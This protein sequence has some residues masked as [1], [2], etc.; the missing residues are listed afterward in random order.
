MHVCTQRWVDEGGAA[1]LAWE[2]ALK[3]AAGARSIVRGW[4]FKV[5]LVLHPQSYGVWH[6]LR[7]AMF[8]PF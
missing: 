4:R 7:A 3:L 2:R 6:Y 1:Q 8:P 5:R